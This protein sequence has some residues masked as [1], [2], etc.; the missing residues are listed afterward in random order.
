MKNCI[1]LLGV[2]LIASFTTFTTTATAQSDCSSKCTSKNN[3]RVTWNNHNLSVSLSETPGNYSYSIGFPTDRT[4]QVED[5]LKKELGRNFTTLTAG[6]KRWT[7]D[8]SKNDANSFKVFCS[9][10]YIRIAYKGT[11]EDRL[12]EAKALSRAVKSLLKEQEG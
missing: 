4:S 12:E 5:Y 8:K 9:K 6:L 2:L 3:T 10:G 11:D 7:T 1:Q